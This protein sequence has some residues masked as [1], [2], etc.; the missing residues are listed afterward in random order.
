MSLPMKWDFFGGK[1]EPSEID[2]ECIKREIREELNIEIEMMDI[3]LPFIHPYSTH[4][5]LQSI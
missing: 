1:L 4:N 3:L 5:L 2:M